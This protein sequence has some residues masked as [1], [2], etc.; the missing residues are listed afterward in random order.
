M[1]GKS[2][3][4]RKNKGSS[5]PT[6][7]SGLAP[8]SEDSRNGLRKMAVNPSRAKSGLAPRSEDSRNGLRKMAVNPFRAKSGLAPRSEDSGD[9]VCKMIE[10]CQI[11]RHNW[12]RTF[13]FIGIAIVAMLPFSCANGPSPSVN[14]G[15][16]GQVG[17]GPVR[18]GIDVLQEDD[19]AFLRG[20]R[21]GLI[22]NQT[23]INRY[24]TQTRVVLH[25]DPRVNLVALY[26]PEHGLDGTEKAAVHISTRKDP[27]TGLTAHS[28]YGPTRKPTSSMLRD[29][30]VML[31]DLQDIGSRS[32]TYISTMV[33]AMEACGENGKQ[34]VVLDRP[35]P[36]GGHRINGPGIEKRWISFVGQVP[37][38]YVHGMTAGEIA[39]MTNEKGWNKRKCNLAVVPMKGWNRGMSWE[40]TGLKWIATSPN[41][42]QKYSPRY[43]AATGIFGS[44]R[45]GDIGI[46]TDR[47]F[48]YIGGYG[49]D[50]HRLKNDFDSMNLDGVQFDSYQSSRKPGWAGVRLKI[51]PN[52]QADIVG[53][54]L[55]GIASVNRYTK[56]SRD[57]FASTPSSAMNIFNKVY[58]SESIKAQLKNGTDP[59]TI[60]DSWRSYH[61]SFR[62]ARQPYLLY[63]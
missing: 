36:L 20:K 22:T 39:R 11:E 30:D 41:I 1:S 34:F 12:R 33:L 53:L 32:Y 58:G 31:F 25:R 52:A 45:G 6:A 7:K 9:R 5:S 19:F 18:L 35:N 61:A 16:G 3:I 17:G 26:T 28:L 59:R 47:P 44:L 2:A 15:F 24:G 42:P 38:P 54:N 23:S 21:V 27:V 51:N 49:V 63:R 13:K 56:S 40:H 62:S 29:I 60:I 14:P 8:R 37:V 50:P 46:G 48:E 57:L 4:A 10:P 43:Y 55:I